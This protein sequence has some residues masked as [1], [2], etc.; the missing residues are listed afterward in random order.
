M[1]GIPSFVDDNRG[2]MKKAK[3]VKYHFNPETLNYERIDNS[4][5]SLAKR[6][7]LHTITSFFLGAVFFLIFIFTVES[8]YQKNLRQEN[9]RIEAQYR[10][11]NKQFEEVQDVLTDLQQRDDNLYRVVFQAEPI[12][13]VERIGAYE[14]TKRFDHLKDMS[15]SDMIIATSKKAA[16]IRHQLYIQ[17]KSF[18]NVV[19]LARNKEKML[20]CIPAIQPVF[21]KNLKRM[22]SGYGMRIDPVYRVPKFHAGMDFTAPTGTKIFATG[23]GTVI[24]SG[25]KQGYGNCVIVN[26]GFNYQTL[27]AHMSKIK[28]N[29]GA[30]L[31]RGEVIGFVGNTGKSTG[32]HLHYE[33]IHKGKPVNPSNYY[34]RDLSPKD[35][36]KM[37][38][39]TTNS[40]QVFD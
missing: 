35:Y 6:F 34:F 1:V 23:N 21:N 8:P 14:N 17:S 31:K 27:Y 4:F 15:N 9:N 29:R 36:D 12:P 18:D 24:Y 13:L 22:A 11:L 25:W 39:I 5:K 20:E 28:V 19:K 26:H 32:P 16:E 30:S 7:A 10:L 3:K 33:V 40:A 37:L 38:Q 2:H